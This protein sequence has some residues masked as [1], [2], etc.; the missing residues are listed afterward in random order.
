MAAIARFDS[1]DRWHVLLAR[2]A[3]FHI[4]LIDLE[5]DCAVKRHSI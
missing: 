1:L 4:N 5:F 2:S 3:S